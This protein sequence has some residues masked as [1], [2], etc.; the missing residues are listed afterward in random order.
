MGFVEEAAVGGS[1]ASGLE[2]KKPKEGFAVLFVAVAGAAGVPVLVLAKGFAS[3]SVSLFDFRKG[4]SVAAGS[5]SVALAN[6]LLCWVPPMLVVEV[7]VSAFLKPKAGAE[8]RAVCTG[9]ASCDKKLGFAGSA[10]RGAE[11]C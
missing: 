10:A 9:F 8:R 7:A 3:N 4:L 2:P 5:L 1:G 11:I 6:G